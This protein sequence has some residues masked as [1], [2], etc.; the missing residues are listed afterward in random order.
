MANQAKL[1][2]YEVPYGSELR[3]PV[4]PPP[5]TVARDEPANPPSP[6]PV[7]IALLERGQ[8]RFDINCAPCHGRVGDGNGMIVQRGFPHPPS[9]YIERL[10]DA[11]NQHFYDV[12]THGYG[13]MYSYAD[14]VE[15]A[16][17]W[18]IAAYIRALQAS[19][20]AALSDVPANQRNALQ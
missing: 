18:A 3:W 8:Q 4:K 7:T 6:P 13:I 11:P 20:S 9:Y 19:A 12:I 15:P 10:R 17:R 5:N 1:N 2:P 16:D 14:R